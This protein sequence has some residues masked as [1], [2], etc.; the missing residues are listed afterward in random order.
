MRRIVPTL[1]CVIIAGLAMACGGT[2]IPQHAGYKNVKAKPWAKAK[3]LKFN[4]K[5]EAKDDDDLSYPAM[6]RAKWYAVEVP[7]AGQLDLR[8]EITP[9]GDGVN[10]DFDLGMEVLDPGNRVISKSDLEDESA[11]ELTKTKSLLD[12]PPGKYLIHLYLQGRLD[13][14]DYILRVAYKRAS[15]GD[16]K[17]DFPAQVL[18][19]EP[20]AMIPVNDDT[21]KSYRPA[22]PIA[23]TSKV[24]RKPRE[25]KDPEKP[26]ATTMSAR[27]IGYS[28]SGA[29]TMITVGRGTTHNAN[30]GMK[31]T[32]KG[33]SGTFQLAN[34]KETSCSALVKATPDQIKQ[35]GGSV[36]I[37]P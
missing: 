30:N 31:V 23:V 25:K 37:S 17:S 3:L 11:G 34:C 12:L 26:V 2:D 1:S 19:L 29:G 27:I 10:E 13:T 14:A 5:M 21:P 32:L 16:V 7:A 6:R 36:V 33:V 4:D 15:S 18:F 28:V 9:P 20:L 22:Q 8:L 35:S 24:I